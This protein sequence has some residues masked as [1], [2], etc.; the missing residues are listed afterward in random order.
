MSSAVREVCSRTS[1]TP[2][3][4]LSP[5]SAILL[6]LALFVDWLP[7]CGVNFYYRNLASISVQVAIIPSHNAQE[8]V[9]KRGYL[10][11]PTADEQAAGK[12]E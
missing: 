1:A 10:Q 3:A 7:M 8:Q 6:L 9:L 11:A 12:Q 2:T 5:P 4:W